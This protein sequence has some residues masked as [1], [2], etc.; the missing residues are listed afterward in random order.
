MLHITKKFLIIFSIVGLFSGFAQDRKVSAGPIPNLK[1]GNSHTIVNTPDI[2]ASIAFGHENVSKSTISMPMPAGTPFN[3]LNIFVPPNGSFASSMTKGGDGNYYLTT[4]EPA[5]YLFNTTT[6]A[7]TLLGTI[8]GLSGDLPNGI[9]YNPAN[10]MYYLISAEKF[11]SFN[12]STRV[13]TLIG[14]MSIPNSLF[15]DLCFN[16]AGACYAYDIYTSAAY[17]INPT[18]GAATLLG[19]L[20]YLPNY[21]Q[22]MS[23]DMETGTIYLSAFNY[24]TNTGQLRTMDLGT[25][26]T[27]LITDW[28]YQQIAPFA[29]NTQY[30]TPCSVGL[31]SNPNPPNGATNLPITGN[32]AT[33]TNGSGTTNTEVWFGSV[34][35]VSKVYD[36]PAITSFALPTLSY[37]TKY[38]WWIVCKN[39]TCKTQGLPWSFT[40]QIDPNLVVAFNDP[41]NNLNCWTPIGP[42]GQVNWSLSNTNNAGG[43]PPS[44]L[45]LFYDPN[46]NGLS[47][48]LSCPISSNN[49]YLNTVTWRQYA[50]Y[51]SGTGPFIGLAVTYDGGATSTI[52]WETQITGN[53]LSE[54]RTASFAPLSN[55][56]QLIFYLN[57]NIFSI[58]LWNIDDLQVDYVVP[59]ELV[60]FTAN[61]T[62]GFVELSWI[63]STETNN[64][65]F[66]IE[67]APS[68]TT[69]G[70]ED[71]ETVG[72]VPGFGTTTEIQ[73]Y[74]YSDRTVTS[75][76]FSY[77]LKQIDFDGTY[78]YSNVVD[79]DVPVLN[80]FA[81]E[82]NYPNPFNPVTKIEFRL[83]VDSKVS[84][85]VFDVLGQEIAVLLNENLTAGVH[86]T[87]FNASSL[88]SGVYLYRIEATG[89]DGN[90]FLD[91]KKMILLK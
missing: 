74:S 1:V 51:Y 65:G 3:T 83:A 9:T 60:S 73:T 84:L 53:I 88:N 91:I 5:L 13:A 10:S 11:Y 54:E 27:T 21:G 64:R 31:P 89:I 55:T 12:V 16:D 19:P 57:G 61:V 35:S 56:Y 26:S 90:N 72:F 81:L 48:I 49:L 82:Q 77:R 79:V 63:T 36:G 41:F 40:T 59:V 34:G 47:Q 62:E 17:I 39:I 75:G 4:K 78:K 70:Q 52:L 80:E 25:G 6:G 23:Y 50:E 28:G 46:F 44:E 86:K 2:L 37:D 32:I 43:S 7:V 15:I 45:V 29:L 33:W 38:L 67:R 20:G 76:K 14:S 68:S 71:W 85:K 42:L 18:T 58:N 22:G 30:G 66:E 24:E 87:D 69:P 8:N